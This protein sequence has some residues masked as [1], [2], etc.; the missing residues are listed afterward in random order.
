MVALV[1]TL[2]LG[3]CAS[4]GPAPGNTA[5]SPGGSL[6]G[7][8][9]LVEAVNGVAIDTGVRAA[10]TFEPGDRNTSI[11]VGTGG[12]NRLRGGWQQAGTAIRL[13]PM[14]GTMMMCE[15]GKMAAEQRLVRGLESATA[16]GFAADGA[17]LLTAADG[18]VVRLRREHP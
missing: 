13:G 14:A 12:C 2:A 7:G 17:A 15:P 10:L 9:W 3:G 11:V 1:A 6:E 16:A 18:G 5:Q 8:P 4:G